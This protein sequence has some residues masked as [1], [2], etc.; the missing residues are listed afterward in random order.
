MIFKVRLESVSGCQA[1]DVVSRH[2]PVGLWDCFTVVS[3]VNTN[4][5]LTA[6]KTRQLVVAA[7]LHVVAASREKLLFLQESLSLW[8]C[9]LVAL[10]AFWI[11]VSWK[12]Q[13][14]PRS[15]NAICWDC[16]A[17]AG[18]LQAASL[19]PMWWRISNQSM[20]TAT[21]HDG[22]CLL[23]LYIYFINTNL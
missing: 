17:G 12:Q 20:H 21:V 10:K 8:S 1:E 16:I 3:A 23:Q 9:T 6:E 18:G 14:M 22:L 5:D 13:V 2:E 11:I 15:P 19:L 7:V 4:W